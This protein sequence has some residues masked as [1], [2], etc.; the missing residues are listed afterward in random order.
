MANVENPVYMTISEIRDS[1]NSKIAN[2]TGNQFT[3]LGE[4]TKFIERNFSSC[5]YTGDTVFD[6]VIT[7]CDRVIGNNYIW[8]FNTF[9]FKH[10]KDRTWFIL[11][12]NTR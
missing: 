7:E 1:L 10:E 6:H 8:Q 5:I 12:F 11:K 4:A 3:S 2:L 9:Y